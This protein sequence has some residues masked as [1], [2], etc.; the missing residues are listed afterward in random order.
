[1]RHFS[2][3]ASIGIWIFAFPAHAQLTAGDD[4]GNV[5]LGAGALSYE[6]DNEGFGG[7]CADTGSFFCGIDNLALAPEAL[8]A[9]YT[10]SYNTGSGYEALISNTTGNYNTASGFEAMLKNT[11]GAQN[12]AY[13][14]YAL[15]GNGRGDYN[16]ALGGYAL[17]SNTSGSSN[18]ALGYKAGF[19]PT[20]GANNIHIGNLGATGDTD[21]IKI[22]T[23]GTQTAV[24]I[25]GASD[26]VSVSGNQSTG[27]LVV[28]T[29]TGQVGIQASSERFKTAVEPMG[30]STARLEELQ[31]VMFKYKSGARGPRQYGLIAED[32]AKVYPEL[33]VRDANGEILSVRYD[34][35]APM[36][37][38]EMKLEDQKNRHENQRLSRQLNAQA[39]EIRE[40][41]SALLTLQAPQQKN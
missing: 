22:G 31:P 3:F 29:T 27:Q 7:V 34:E 21:L 20:A 18:I 14:F 28:N 30:S 24:F 33:V 9:N 1:M 11:S 5:A 36:L 40:L 38:N 37:L 6:L 4:H 26:A 25:A 23:Q 39:A 10:G 12:S 16:T 13:G 35:L 17:Y 15:H 32:V 2:L 41:K 19:Y 8:A